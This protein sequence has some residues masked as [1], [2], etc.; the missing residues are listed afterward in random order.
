MAAPHF[1]TKCDFYAVHAKL[2]LHWHRDLLYIYQNGKL[3]GE[4]LFTPAAAS[5]SPVCCAVCTVYT[6]HI[7]SKSRWSVLRARCNM[8]HRFGVHSAHHV[9]GNDEYV[10][11]M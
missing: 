4:K 7:N 11:Y 9:N 5:L 1:E 2:A 10:M 6:V 3:H 8:Y